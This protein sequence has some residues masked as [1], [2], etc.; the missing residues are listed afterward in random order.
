MNGTVGPVQV[1]TR[2]RTLKKGSVWS[3][4]GLDHGSEPNLPITISEEGL[5]SLLVPSTEKE[6]EL[7]A[8][9]D[10]RCDIAPEDSSHRE[11]QLTIPWNRAFT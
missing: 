6:H 8:K 11:K 4:S 10:R 5:A 1:N 9:T 3:G 7:R 2:T